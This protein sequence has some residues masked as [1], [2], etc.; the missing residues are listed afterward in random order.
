VDGKDQ[1]GVTIAAHAT[2]DKGL[3][4]VLS[5]QARIRAWQCEDL[6]AIQIPGS[7]EDLPQDI[8]PIVENTNPDSRR[9]HPAEERL[10]LA[11]AD[12]C[13]SRAAPIGAR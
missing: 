1:G 9:T 2:N 10:A 5:G 12:H 8:R 13:A 4:S 11:V 7:V 3:F 6:M